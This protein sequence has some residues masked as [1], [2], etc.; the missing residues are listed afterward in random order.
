VVDERLVDGRHR[1]GSTRLDPTLGRTELCRSRRLALGRARSIDR[2]R[3]RAEDAARGIP[4]L[5]RE[6]AGVLE[7]LAPELLVVA[8]RRAVEQRESEGVRTGGVDR[9]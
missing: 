1:G 3:S 5:V 4:Q 9:L 7:L 8:G 2:G 6:V